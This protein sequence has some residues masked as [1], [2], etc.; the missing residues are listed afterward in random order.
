MIAVLNGSS[1]GVVL[2]G[3]LKPTQDRC[4]GGDPFAADFAAREL[5]FLEEVVDR[6]DGYREEFGGH[7]DVKDFRNLG[8]RRAG[9]GW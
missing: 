1:Q 6:I 4:P 3:L 8:E 2:G 7:P 5:S 9:N